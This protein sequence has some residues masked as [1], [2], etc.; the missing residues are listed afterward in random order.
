MTTFPYPLSI[1]KINGEP[2]FKRVPK[3]GVMA[4]LR[5]V[6]DRA[7]CKYDRPLKITAEMIRTDP[8]YERWGLL[9]GY[10]SESVKYGSNMFSKVTLHGQEL[11]NIRTLDSKLEAETLGKYSVSIDHSHRE[12]CILELLLTF[13]VSN[14]CRFLKSILE[15]VVLFKM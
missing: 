11:E 15:C 3:S 4:E 1:Y 8:V 2:R 5:D 14:T 7:R 12:Q 13:S 9:P 6:C 10:Q